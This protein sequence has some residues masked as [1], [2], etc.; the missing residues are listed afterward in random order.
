MGDFNDSSDYSSEEVVAALL[1]DTILMILRG[2]PILQGY[3]IQ[4][5]DNHKRA[6]EATADIISIVGR[7][8]IQYADELD[9]Q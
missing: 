4:Y 3:L 5:K 6:T 2:H 8:L 9:T 7:R 1:I